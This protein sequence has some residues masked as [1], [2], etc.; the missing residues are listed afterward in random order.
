MNDHIMH[1]VQSCYTNFINHNLYLSWNFKFHA[2]AYT[3]RNLDNN[4]FNLVRIAQNIQEI[5]GFWAI[6]K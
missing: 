6:S 3:D 4:H 1:G 2:L 5:Y